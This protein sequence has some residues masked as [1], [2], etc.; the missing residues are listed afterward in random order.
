M[1]ID[2]EVLDYQAAA[3]A[4]VYIWDSRR[5]STGVVREFGYESHR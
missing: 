5:F 3:T 1:P 4:A 2:G